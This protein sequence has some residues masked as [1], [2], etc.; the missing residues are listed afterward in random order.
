MRHKILLPTDF[1]DNAWHAINYATELYKG[2]ETDFYILNVFS[3]TSN[4]IESF[5]NLEP[6]S[7]LYETKKWDSEN[8]L[9]KVLEKLILREKSDRKHRFKTISMFNNTIEAIKLV[10]DKKD[11]EL[12]I[13]GTKGET[14]SRSTA[15]G[16]TAIYVMEKVRNCPVIVVP[17]KA[18]IRLPKE[19]VF[20]TGFKTYYKRRELKHLT[21]IAKKSDAEIVVLHVKESDKLS[22]TK[23]E[24]KA[25]LEEILQDTKYKFHM[26]SHNA[27]ITAINIFVE[28][29]NSDMV[30]FINRKHTFFG[31]ILT[32]PM[33]KEISFHLNVPILAMHDLK[34]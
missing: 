22:E 13:M 34:N 23:K 18:E 19:I 4:L 16:S 14:Y 29:R 33:V 25:L 20:P 3:A 15:F 6:G 1:S 17:N 26:L 31:S 7:E 10:V 5:I 2:Q 9:A 30:A 24:N 21:D 12:I 27:V 11:I 8:G 28:S 32:N